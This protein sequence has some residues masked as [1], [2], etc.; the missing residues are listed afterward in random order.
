MKTR[1]LIGPRAIG[2]RVKGSRFQRPLEGKEGAFGVIG[3][4]ER[5][6]M[7]FKHLALKVPKSD[8]YLST[9]VLH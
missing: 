2:E 9:S 4:Q 7:K 1:G 6:N 5:I 8:I 3:D